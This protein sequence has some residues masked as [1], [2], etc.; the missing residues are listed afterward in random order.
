MLGSVPITSSTQ[1]GLTLAIFYLLLDRSSE[2]VIGWK[3]TFKAKILQLDCNCIELPSPC[4]SPIR[5]VLLE[6]HLYLVDSLFF[7][8]PYLQSEV[9]AATSLTYASPFCYQAMII[10]LCSPS[11]T[12]CFSSDDPTI[13]SSNAWD[14]PMFY[15][16]LSPSQLEIHQTHVSLLLRSSS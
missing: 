16:S 2:W 3:L 10:Q 8:N 12:S 11:T 6:F 13:S 5:R 15:S 9:R 14:Q 7:C 1:S 4:G